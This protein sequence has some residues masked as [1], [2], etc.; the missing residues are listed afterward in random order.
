M[1]FSILTASP[2]FLM[3]IET[4]LLAMKKIFAFIFALSLIACATP[5]KEKFATFPSGK[6][7][8]LSYAYDEHTIFWPTS[9]SFHLDTVFAGM[10]E[11]GY[12]YTAF[13]FCLAEHG[14]THLDAPIHF[15][16]GKWAADEIPIDR[17]IG[18][19]VVIDVSEKALQD[20]DYLISVADVESW[21]AEHGQI[22]ED[23]ILLFRTG[24]GKFWPDRVQYM[25]TAKLGPEGVAE[26][27]FPGIAPEL[28]TWLV[29]NRNIKAAGLDTP[30]IDYGQSTL[31]ESHRILYEKN[32]LGLENL[33]NLDQLPAKGAWVIALPMKIKGG[34]GGPLRMAALIPD[35][36]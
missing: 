25:G 34:S 35:L 3:E 14:G 8:D 11:G 13:K 23:A 5:P 12:Y 2:Y 1:E 31:F 26:L 18:E 21:E 33:A 24:Y 29:E 19:A 22:P 9:E 27:H 16:E 10:A 36:P 32:I 28:A 6:W 20:S 7:I 17:G 15:S 30:S 4:P